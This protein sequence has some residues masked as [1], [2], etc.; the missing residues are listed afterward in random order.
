MTRR[1]AKIPSGHTSMNA[2]P[3]REVMILFTSA[4]PRPQWAP[5]F[6]REG[7]LRDEHLGVRERA[8]IGQFPGN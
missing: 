1:S 7:S 4:S 3:P 2:S 5:V 8:V 6:L